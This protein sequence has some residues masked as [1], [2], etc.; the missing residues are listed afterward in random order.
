MKKIALLIFFVALHS[1]ILNSQVWEKC[2]KGLDFSYQSFWEMDIDPFNENTIIVNN[3]NRLF[4]SYDSGDNWIRLGIPDN[5]DMQFAKIYNGIIYISED[6][7]NGTLYVTSDTGKSYNKAVFSYEDLISGK[8]YNSEEIRDFTF[9]NNAVYIATMNGAYKSD[10]GLLKW[11]H[12]TDSL[13]RF[14]APSV[15]NVLVKDSLIFL[16]GRR[17]GIYYSSDDGLTWEKRNNGFKSGLSGS[18]VDTEMLF[19]FGDT[20]FNFLQSPEDSTLPLYITRDNGLYWEEFLAPKQSSTRPEIQSYK[21][22][23]YMRIDDMIYYTSD[24][25]KKWDSFR[26]DSLFFFYQLNCWGF[27]SKYFFISKRWFQDI[28]Y[29]SGLFRAKWNDGVFED[30]TSI[31]NP[32]TKLDDI[33]ISPNPASDYIEISCPPSEK[34][35]LGGVSVR[36]FDLLGVQ[37]LPRPV[38]HPFMLEGEV[39]R[40]DISALSPGMYFVRVGDVVRKFVKM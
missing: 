9:A 15:L 23:L 20:I 26:K 35:G 36:F 24:F 2:N 27:N 16:S 39:L 30:G 33:S 21:N 38:G 4:I 6:R 19:A 25:G 40:I 28:G 7:L 13:Q 12:L 22:T 5:A 14:F 3:E 29:P 34:R 32:T 8:I 37:Q 11:V 18:W 10:L 1:S 17:F 31:N